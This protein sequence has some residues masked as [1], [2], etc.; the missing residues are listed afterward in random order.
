MPKIL[1]FSFRKC[2]R[3]TITTFEDFM[4]CWRNTWNFQLCHSSNTITVIIFQGDTYHFVCKY[5]IEAFTNAHSKSFWIDH[6][7]SDGRCS[8]LF[9]DFVSSRRAFL[10]NE[11]EK[12][13]KRIHPRTDTLDFVKFFLLL[14]Q[15]MNFL[16]CFIFI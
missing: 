9:E 15:T 2:F 4:K 5:L 8:A 14:F 3:R 12:N 11:L 16:V 6:Q 7:Y 10:T 1:H 13:N